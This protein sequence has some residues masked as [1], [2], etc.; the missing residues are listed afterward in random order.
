LQNE[1]P[2]CIFVFFFCSLDFVP[3]CRWS[4]SEGHFR[5]DLTQD[6]LLRIYSFE[7]FK[8]RKARCRIKMFH[9]NVD[10]PCPREPSTRH[11]LARVLLEITETRQ[12]HWHCQRRWKRSDIEQRGINLWS[13]SSPDGR[14]LKNTAV[15]RSVPTSHDPDCDFCRAQQG[16]STVAGKNASGLRRTRHVCIIIHST[17]SLLQ[18]A[19]NVFSSIFKG[20]RCDVPIR[21]II[22][23]T[24]LPHLRCPQRRVQAQTIA[25]PHESEEPREARRAPE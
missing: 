16:R 8:D 1:P 13:N 18:K 19:L 5:T 12:S 21:I 10:M 14:Q 15:C 7:L 23:V 22:D 11:F 24:L 9:G 25:P 17:K 3:G 2:C 6:Q 4:M 20:C